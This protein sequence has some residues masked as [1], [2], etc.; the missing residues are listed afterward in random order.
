MPINILCPK[1]NGL[2]GL[3]VPGTC[4]PE[5]PTWICLSSCGW[6]ADT[7][8]MELSRRDHLCPKHGIPFCDMPCGYDRRKRP[9]PEKEPRHAAE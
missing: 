8:E 5:K 9:A 7:D 2:A 4:G 1:C 3:Q 6:R